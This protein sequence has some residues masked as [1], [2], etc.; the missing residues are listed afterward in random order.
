MVV[1]YA[2]LYFICG[3]HLYYRSY[4]CDFKISHG[5]YTCFIYFT[6]LLKAGQCCFYDTGANNS[7]E[8]LFSL[9]YT[10][11]L[12]SSGIILEYILTSAIS[13][14]QSLPQALI[15]LSPAVV[16]KFIVNECE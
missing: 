12:F 9:L 14:L 5:Y 10:L 6:D 16:D 1:D 2:C 3:L 11:R 15:F 13:I 8:T 7:D 4:F